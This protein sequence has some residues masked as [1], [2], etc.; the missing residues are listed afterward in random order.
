M[1]GKVTFVTL[2]ELCPPPPK[3]KSACG[4]NVVII[5]IIAASSPWREQRD[6]VMRRESGLD[7]VKEAGMQAGNSHVMSWRRKISRIF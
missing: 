5:N 2:E 1:I 7:A 3:K 4:T 6:V